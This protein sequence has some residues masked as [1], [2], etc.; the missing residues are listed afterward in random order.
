MR[1]K[2]V[3]TFVAV[4]NDGNGDGNGNGN[5]NR[6]GTEGV[7]IDEWQ[8]GRMYS[9]FNSCVWVQAVGGKCGFA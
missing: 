1:V 8:I 4:R 5:G 2:G 3:N 7:G 9:E 6:N